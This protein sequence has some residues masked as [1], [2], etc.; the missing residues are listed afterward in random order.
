M[1]MKIDIDISNKI[2]WSLFF[3]RCLKKSYQRSY[4]RCS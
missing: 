4:R 2:T 3:L 1:S